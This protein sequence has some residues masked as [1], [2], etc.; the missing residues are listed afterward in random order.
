MDQSKPAATLRYGSI[1]AAIWQNQGDKG[2]FYSVTFQRSYKE[3]E[4][5]KNVQ[6]FGREDL[7]LVAK[8]ADLAH[9]KIHELDHTE[10]E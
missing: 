5:F 4:S 10:S 3:G 1:S 9:T 2:S 7:L 6:S 8:L